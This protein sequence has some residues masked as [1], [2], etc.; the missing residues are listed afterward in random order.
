MVLALDLY[1]ALQSEDPVKIRNLLPALMENAVGESGNDPSVVLATV[2]AEYL[3]GDKTAA[4]QD[5]LDFITNNG[6]DS[7]IGLILLKLNV[8]TGDFESFTSNLRT[9]LT[10]LNAIQW[11]D[12]LP[13]TYPQ[14][15]DQP[16]TVASLLDSASAIELGSGS[17]VRPRLLANRAL[18][19]NPYDYIAYLQLTAVD[20]VDKDIASAFINLN[21]ALAL[22]PPS[23][24]RTRVRILQFSSLASESN[25]APWDSLAIASDLDPLLSHLESE[26]P[27]NSFNKSSRAELLGFHGDID[28]AISEY[29]DAVALPGATRETALRL[30]YWLARAGRIDEAVQVINLSIPF[31]SPYLMWVTAIEQEAQIKADPNLAEFASR[32]H[33]YLDPENTHAD[34]F[35]PV[36]GD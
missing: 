17:R 18:M 22:A 33:V 5:A 7:N 35:N 2:Y 15:V 14:P 12:A 13:D 9:T 19:L 26:Y 20:I 11:L 16:M 29:T 25:V 36:E 3:E 24:V 28:G 21:Q 4:M 30:G 27:F 8:E 10:Q 31:D 32:I 34:F 1:D 6:F 23:D